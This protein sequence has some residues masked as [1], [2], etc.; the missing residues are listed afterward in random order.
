M[1]SAARSWQHPR[2][3]YDEDGSDAA[4]R[5]AARVASQERTQPRGGP[6]RA[7]SA[8]R[9]RGSTS[10]PRISRPMPAPRLAP[11]PPES[12]PSVPVAQPQGGRVHPAGRS[13]APGSGE[14]QH[15]RDGRRVSLRPTPR[16]TERSQDREGRPA[17]QSG[18]PDGSSARGSG[19]ARRWAWSLDRILSFSTW[20]RATARRG[21]PARRIAD[22]C[23][24]WDSVTPIGACEPRSPLSR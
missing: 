18:R 5:S 7:V 17:D 19:G 8:T 1:A 23:G 2:W 20:E 24:R 3:Q 15:G 21:S 4:R 22:P 13:G 12:P 6:S 16:S 11:P 14:S 10:A 9:T